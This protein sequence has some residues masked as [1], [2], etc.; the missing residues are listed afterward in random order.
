MFGP[1]PECGSY[2]FF[3]IDT[4]RNEK[5]EVVEVCVCDKCTTRFENTYEK[6]LKI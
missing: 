6:N 1:C 4:K 5:D 3:V 2:N